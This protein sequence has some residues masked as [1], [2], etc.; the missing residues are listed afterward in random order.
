M[1]KIQ[2]FIAANP[3][4]IVVSSTDAEAA[5]WIELYGL[6]KFFPPESKTRDWIGGVHHHPTHWV[7]FGIFHTTGLGRIVYFYPKSKY[8]A[9]GIRD[10]FANPKKY[11]DYPPER[12]L[13]N[14]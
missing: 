7:M 8:S 5:E 3:H 10:F 11:G 4:E 9:E 2:E 12:P 13:S 1:P 6:Q 14:N